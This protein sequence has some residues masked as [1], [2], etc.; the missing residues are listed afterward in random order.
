MMFPLPL[1][2]FEEY[3]L[4]DDRPTHPMSFFLK[5]TFSGPCDP[6]ALSAALP[7]V[8]QRH[9]LLSA[10]IEELKRNQLKWSH[11]RQET[12]NV[13]WVSCDGPMRAT[14]I[15]L[16]SEPGLRISA[17]RLNQ[18]TEFV[19]QFHHSCCDAIGALRF[20]E[21]LLVAY[22]A[23][24]AGDAGSNSFRSI[25]NRQLLD[26]SRFGMTRGKLLRTLHK[27]A[28]GLL[29]VR[30]FL[31]R[32]P[33]PIQPVDFETVNAPLS[34]GFPA[35]HAHRFSKSETAGL[36][37][38]AREAG[39]TVN[40]LLV[41][42][43]FL[44]LGNFRTQRQLGDICEWLRLLIPINLRSHDNELLSAANAVSMIFLDRQPHAFDDGPALLDGINQEMDLIK[45]KRLGLIFP[46]AL[47]FR[48]SFPGAIARL[49]RMSKKQVCH[50]TAVLS[51]LGR[52]L[53]EV[54]LPRRD[55]KLVAAEMTLERFDFLPPIRPYTL[56]AF[57][58]F[59][60]ADR[61][62]I[63]LHF[64][65]HG[66]AD[67]DAKELLKKY[68]DRLGKTALGDGSTY[69]KKPMET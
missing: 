63:A 61:M 66:L 4:I 31:M 38:A 15:D 69:P 30:Q 37:A 47:R 48:R 54:P 24:V 52:P 42:D 45:Q 58:T 39:T 34:R 59:T 23:A 22:A 16:F 3:M 12:I 64:D 46:L 9:P 1:A 57:G 67:A 62:Q 2:P 33:V 25:D 41:R 10:T 14:H 28:V 49:R 17:R 26:R 60:Y 18:E 19:L 8:L 20:L 21:D 35:M 5:L 56:A 43:L 27:Q 36:V 6:A 32:Q 65:A 29:G 50:A 68:I 40:D 55:G 51:N 13:T 44:A 11:D 7:L 53:L